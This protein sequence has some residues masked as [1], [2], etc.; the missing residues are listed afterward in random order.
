MMGNLNSLLNFLAYA[1]IFYMVAIGLIYLV[2]FFIATPKIRREHK[3]HRRE[4]IKDL[5]HSPDTYPVSVLVPA[6]NEELGVTTTVHSLLGLDY[7]QFEVLVINDGSKDKTSERM[8]EEFNMYQVTMPVRKHF[9]TAQVKAV[10]RSKEHPEVVLIEKENGG[11]ADALNAG[12]NVS[13]YPYFAAIDGDSILEKD[14]LLKTMKPI[15]DSNGGVTA[16]G[17]TVRIANGSVV[18]N[19]I[20]E[21]ISLPRQPIAVM[22]IIEYFRAFLIGRLG[23]SRMNLLL[24][25]SG[26]FGVFEKS[27]VIRAGGFDTNTVGEDMEL[28]VRLHRMLKEEKSSQRIEYIQDPVCWTEAPSD[29]RSLKSQRVRWQRGLAETLWKHRKM[30]L[31]PK[32]RGVG[33]FSMPYYLLVE[34]LSCVLELVGYVLIIAGLFF[35]LVDAHITGL[36]IVV[37]ILYG[38]LLSALAVLLEEWTYHKYEELRS[39]IILYLWALSETFWYRPF[40]VWA[41][42][43]GIIAAFKKKHSW[44]TMQRKGLAEEK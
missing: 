30:M 3:L 5:L 21:K 34:L 10:Y 31:N 1:V 27:R 8:I 12:I 29:I 19:S 28:I 9:P 41:Q 14:A 24:I 22:Q 18:R 43:L 36:M 25:I 39:I 17:G 13:K 40:M 6:Y 42:F 7:P 35:G 2:L 32:Y 15:I 38:S 37:T 16:T 26:A 11:K 33:T 23:L 44:G 20:V 4:P